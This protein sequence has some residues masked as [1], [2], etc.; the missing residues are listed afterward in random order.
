MFVPSGTLCTSAT[1]LSGAPAVTRLPHGSGLLYFFLHLRLLLKVP[2]PQQN[3]MKA[4]I[5]YVV[6]TPTIPSLRRPQQ[7]GLKLEAILDYIVNPCF[8]FKFFF[9]IIFGMLISCVPLVC[10]A[11]HSSSANYNYLF[12]QQFWCSKERIHIRAS[13]KAHSARCLLPSLRT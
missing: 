3:W 7:K 10:L 13:E 5:Q 9:N 6:Y 2:S 12:V 8:C 4:F 1:A 11:E